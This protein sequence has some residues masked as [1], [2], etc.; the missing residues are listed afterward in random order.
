[1]DERGILYHI[2]RFLWPIGVAATFVGF[3]MFLRLG[4]IYEACLQGFIFLMQIYV[5]P[6]KEDD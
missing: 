3:I 5:W 4:L 2:V 1:M 6:K